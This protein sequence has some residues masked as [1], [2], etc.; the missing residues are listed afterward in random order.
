MQINT[1]KLR[2]LVGHAL[3]EDKRVWEQEEV[4][5]EAKCA[6]RR[7][8]WLDRNSA[9]WSEFSKTIIE[10]VRAG[11]PITEDDVPEDPNA[12]RYSRK[13]FFSELRPSSR[14]EKD[15]VKGVAVYTPPKDLVRFQAFLELVEGDTITTSALKDHGLAQINSKVLQFVHDARER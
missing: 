2:E 3:A 14:H 5:F 11:V 8:D 10:K 9:S 1:A 7:Q 13:A 15:Y 4:D 12:D 6:K